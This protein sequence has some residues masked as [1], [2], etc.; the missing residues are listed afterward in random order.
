MSSTKGSASKE[1][2]NSKNENKAEGKGKGM[3][4][5]QTSTKGSTQ[6]ANR[7]REVHDR[8]SFAR[9]KRAVYRGPRRAWGW[10]QQG[11]VAAGQAAA[12]ADASAGCRK[13]EP[14]DRFCNAKPECDTDAKSEP[15]T[16]VGCGNSVAGWYQDNRTA[17]DDH[18][19]V[20]AVGQKRAARRSRELRRPHRRRCSDVRARRRRVDIPGSDR[21]LSAVPR[22]QLLRC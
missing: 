14:D 9:K 6:G 21:R 12:C 1:E 15:D 11:T 19:A 7:G 8:P 4:T 2:S 3:T 10:R 22:S 18:P 16:T 13:T 17:A 20:S 5:G